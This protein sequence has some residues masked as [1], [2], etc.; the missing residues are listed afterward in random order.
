[1][2]LAEASKGTT[3]IKTI[4]VISK[5]VKITGKVPLLK[6]VLPLKD[7]LGL[8]VNSLRVRK[9][10]TKEV[11]GESAKVKNEN[12]FFSWSDLT[13]KAPKQSTAAIFKK[14]RNSLEVIK[15]LALSKRISIYITDEKKECLTREK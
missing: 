6:Y 2:G 3:T 12:L 9:A 10:V 11:M 1:M 7:T 15:I 8:N 4:I 5:D 13:K 14:V